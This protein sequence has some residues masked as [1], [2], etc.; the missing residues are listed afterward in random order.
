MHIHAAAV[1][2]QLK[3]LIT[4]VDRRT[5]DRTQANPRFIKQDQVAIARFELSQAGQAVCM[6]SFKRFPQ[7]GR[8]TLRDE[9]RTVAVGKILKIVE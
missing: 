2:V 7:L 5:G 9:G 8:F 6:E 3:K 4:L 1:E